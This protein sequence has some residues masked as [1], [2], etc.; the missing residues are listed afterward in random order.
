MEL[1][2]YYGI[3]KPSSTLWREMGIAATIFTAP[4]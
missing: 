1:N 4:M 2:G 3:P